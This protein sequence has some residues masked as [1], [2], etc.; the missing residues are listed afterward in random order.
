MRNFAARWGLGLLLGILWAATAPAQAPASAVAPAVGRAPGAVTAAE[1]LTAFSGQ[2]VT[3]VELAGWPGLATGPLLAR[4]PQKAGQPLRPE[5][6]QAS[7]A[8]LR[9]VL[10]GPVAGAPA[11]QQLQDIQLQ[12]V[13]EPGGVLVEFI[14]EPAE[15]VGVYE[16]SGV[17]E[18]AYTQ[19]LEAANYQSRAP[20]AAAEVAAGAAGL[21]QYYRE[22][23]YFTAQVRPQ[24]LAVPGGGVVNVDFRTRL[25]PKARYGQIDLQ[26]A[27]PAEAARLRG[28]LGSWMARLRRS[29]VYPGGGYSFDTLQSAVRYLQSA[30]NQQGFLA[31]QVSLGGATY[32]RG[33]NRADI[34]FLVRPGPVVQIHIEGAFLWPWTRRSL[35]PIYDESR[36][37]ADLIQQGQDNLVNYFSA[38]GY[39]NAEVTTTV[40]SGAERTVMRESASS[41]A[42]LPPPAGPPGTP[43]HP[44][45]IV[46]R[47]DKGPRHDVESV[48]FSGNHYYRAADLMPQVKIVPE[49]FFSHGS[50]NQVLLNASAGGIRALYQQAGY[51]AAKV[52]PKVTHPG[53][54]LAVD[55]QVAEGRQEFVQALR[56]VGNTLPLGEL[57]PEGFNLGPGTPFS[58]Q[59]V[60]QDRAQILAQYLSRGYLN[61][62]FRASAQRVAGHPSEVNVVY[63]IYEGPQ[64][65]IARI[66][67]LGRVHS[68][69]RLVDRLTENLQPEHL[70][71]ENDMLA[72]ESRLYAPGVFDWTEVGPRR[73]ITNQPEA[74]LLVKVHEAARNSLTYGFGF[75]VTNRGGSIPSGT[76]ALPG[77]PIVGLPNSFVTSQS[78]FYGPDA[79]I[80]YTRTDVFGKG[81]T[82]N[83][84][85]YAGRLDQHGSVTYTDPYLAWS[86]FS[87]NLLVS[88]EH[89][90]TNPIFTAKEAQAGLQLDRPLNPDKTINLFFRYTFS[91][92][93]LTNLLI[94]DL[95][96]AQ[97][98]SIRLSTLSATWLRDTRDNPLD[99]HKGIL[100]SYELDYNPG[101]LGSS[102]DFMKF[103]S[104]TA[105]YR[106]ILGGVVFAN[107][108]RFGFEHAFGHSF[109]PLS[110]AFFSGGGSTLRG[111]PLD[112]AGPQRTLPA[113]GNPAV[114]STCTLIRV[115]V[116]GHALFIF[117]SELR[118]PT[119]QINSHLG[120]ALFYDGG[121]VFTHLGFTNLGA[122]FSNT[123]GVGLRY[124]TP[125]G[126]IRIDVGRNLS[127]IAGI[128]ATQYFVTLGQ[129]F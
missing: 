109:I 16:F 121:N 80:E 58:Q 66:L 47:V 52:T 108:L 120:L 39:F 6:V 99:A 67:T 23:G 21:E 90:A 32:H 98:L 61:A 18:F 13:P 46:Y 85:G 7:L 29:A 38:H 30:L 43:T 94:P 73:P 92:T 119:P 96:P 100:E 103:N 72:A 50:F 41:A 83:V 8:D 44:T 70:L 71:T 87:S 81:A 59:L 86:R 5:L 36:V 112:G 88:A 102:V 95:V 114:P 127:P 54:N 111:F 89:D 105:Y 45:R 28:G 75:D 101:A 25:G 17:T 97:D 74:E 15:Y 4:M 24:V 126:P 12:I 69:Q 125:V 113:C 118:I 26:G 57:A 22:Q 65:R 117:N 107:S 82:F 49:H 31:A 106:R 60:S 93:S 9:R 1:T 56:I 51:S 122:N 63:N 2:N 33:T 37:D 104:Q 19:L 76:V 84:G 124:A 14:L 27:T 128:A 35:I 129:A 40:T 68:Q 34:T 3:A 78:T 123:L 11:G 91:E 20:Y 53:G 77:L 62:T 64:V 42:P 110:Q 55:F 10:T 48:R 115:P 116:G 79:T